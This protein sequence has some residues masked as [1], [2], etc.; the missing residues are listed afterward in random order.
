MPLRHD[1]AVAFCP[2]ILVL[3]LGCAKP[4]QDEAADKDT[5][6]TSAKTSQK[7]LDFVVNEIRD[8]Q[9]VLDA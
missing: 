9:D 7:H 8:I 4:T 1:F 6:T 2:F 5:E 3:Q